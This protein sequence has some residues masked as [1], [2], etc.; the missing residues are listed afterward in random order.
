MTISG[1]DV[2][3][4]F[5][6]TVQKNA[7]ITSLVRELRLY[8]SRLELEE[9]E[10]HIRL[11]GICTNV[12]NLYLNGCN[13]SRLDDLKTALGKADLVSLKLWHRPSEFYQRGKGQMP[14]IAEILRLLPKWPRIEEVSGF[15]G[16]RYGVRS[17]SMEAPIALEACTALRKIA[18]FDDTFD[19]THLQY[20]K[21]I[22]PNLEDITF[23]IRPRS[24]AALRDCLR[25]WSSSLKRL[26]IRTPSHNKRPLHEGECPV[27]R[28]PIPEIRELNMAAP[29]LSVSALQYVPRLEKLH[30]TEGDF[31]QGTQLAQI[32]EEGVLPCL[33][34]IDVSFSVST[35][36]GDD[37]T[38]G[39][40]TDLKMKVAEEL[41]RVCKKRDIFVRDSLTGAEEL[42]AHYGY[43]KES[44]ESSDN[45]WR[46]A[47]NE[48]TST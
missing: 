2:G 28:F 46:E 36:V 12:E 5:C 19:P 7:R 31:S 20:L 8:T 25:F 26:S 37:I 39:D 3:R 21:A 9:S 10:T 41:R 6:E 42:E 33:R 44:P 34:E 24:F 43:H 47:H 23:T 45:D 11:I 14:T 13:T 40:V 1:K 30:L 27:I 16:D 4:R 48:P 22:A 29:L 35:G 38:P 32:I 17:K 18:I 15:L